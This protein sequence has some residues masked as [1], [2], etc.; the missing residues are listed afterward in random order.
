[1]KPATVD[2]YI[3]AQPAEVAQM[4]EQLR[5]IIRSVVPEDTEEIISYM[6]PSYKYHGMLVG[7]GARKSG[8]SFYAMSNTI[9]YEFEKELQGLT[10]NVST[11][12]F[13]LGKKLPVTL[14]KKIT[15]QRIK[16]N[17][18]KAILKQQL[19]NNKLKK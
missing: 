15:K 3:A 10:Y 19:K 8:C 11:L 18:E 16:Y 14:I 4:L 5:S 2:Q 13:D 9:L 17:K 6:V 1:M 7:F 12:H